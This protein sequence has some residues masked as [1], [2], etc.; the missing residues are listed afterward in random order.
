MY[1]QPELDTPK[2]QRHFLTHENS[3]V[4]SPSVFIT[5]GTYFILAFID[6][7]LPQYPQCLVAVLAMA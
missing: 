2:L 7:T 6:H 1:A 3:C 5:L 4:Q